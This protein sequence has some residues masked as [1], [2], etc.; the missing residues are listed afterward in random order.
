MYKHNRIIYFFKHFYL[1]VKGIWTNVCVIN[2]I[3]T[4]RR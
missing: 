2:G 1:Y 3:A 4:F